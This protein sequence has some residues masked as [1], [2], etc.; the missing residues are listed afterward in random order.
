M[1]TIANNIKWII[2]IHDAAVINPVDAVKVRAIYAEQLQAIHADRKMIL[3]DYFKSINIHPDAHK[4]WKELLDMVEPL[5]GSLKVN[6]M[7]MK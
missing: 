7:A 4:Q 1:D 3:N 6:E 5:E 2:P